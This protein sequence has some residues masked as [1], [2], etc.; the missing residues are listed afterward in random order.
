MYFYDLLNMYICLHLFVFRAKNIQTNTSSNIVHQKKDLV[1][2]VERVKA[3][4]LENEN[5]RKKINQSAPNSSRMLNPLKIDFGNSYNYVLLY[6][7]Y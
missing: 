6:I 2:Y 4:E 3:L 5:L 7:T 1:Y